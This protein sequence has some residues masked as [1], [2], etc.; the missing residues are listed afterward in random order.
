MKRPRVQ[1]T[2]RAI[3]IVVGLAALSTWPM[4][5]RRYYGGLATGHARQAVRISVEMHGSP[6]WREWE[7][8]NRAWVGLGPAAEGAPA[9]DRII[10]A[11]RRVSDDL[12]RRYVRE[13]EYHKAM[14]RECRDAADRPWLAI[15]ADPNPSAGHPDRSA[16]ADPTRLHGNDAIDLMNG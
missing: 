2:I 16:I 7:R 1:F 14:A 8:L 3:M 4:A 13:F 12:E 15:P 5:L 9:E 6:E 11:A 10:V